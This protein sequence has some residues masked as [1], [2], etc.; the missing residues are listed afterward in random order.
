LPLVDSNKLFELLE[1]NSLSLFLYSFGTGVNIF[2]YSYFTKGEV[3]L[4]TNLEAE[5][6]SFKLF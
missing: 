2:G 5:E 4:L 3:G 6:L 1:L